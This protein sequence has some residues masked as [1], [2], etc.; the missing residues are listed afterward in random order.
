MKLRLQESKVNQ[1]LF[2]DAD[3]QTIETEFSLGFEPVYHEDNL[4]LFTIVFDFA[5]IT[6]DEKY[7]RVDYQCNFTTDG[8]LD[9]KFKN[10]KFPIVNAPAIAFPF[11]RAFVANF[12]MSSG[13]KPIL[14]PSINFVNFSKEDI[15]KPE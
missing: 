5:Y 15:S 4:N 1:L 3:G 10:S 2:V 6:E 8:E 12:L 9:E 14:L 13:Y 7:L 11:L